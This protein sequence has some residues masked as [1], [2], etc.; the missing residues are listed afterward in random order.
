MSDG[1]LEAVDPADHGALRKVVGHRRRPLAQLGG[2]GQLGHTIV[3]PALT[4]TASPVMA[5]ASSESSQQMVAAISSAALEATE[6]DL[7]VDEG[8]QPALAAEHQ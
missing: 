3:C 5:R 4:L 1:G 6:G 7:P 8:L 2:R